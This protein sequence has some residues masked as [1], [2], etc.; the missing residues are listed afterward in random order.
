[1]EVAHFLYPM[2]RYHGKVKPENLVFNANLQEFSLK[3]TYLCNLQT[4]GKLTPEET[5]Q[6]IQSLWQELSASKEQLGIG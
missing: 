5:Y 1:M 6:R 3:V 2:S 4:N